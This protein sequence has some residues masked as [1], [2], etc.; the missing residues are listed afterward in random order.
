MFECKGKTEDIVPAEKGVK[1]RKKPKKELTTRGG[2][3]KISKRLSEGKP[4]GRRENR[5][6]GPASGA[7]KRSGD[8]KKFLTKAARC[9]NLI[10]SPDEGGGVRQEVRGE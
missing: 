3:A 5:I 7:E 2:S 8:Q 1:K 9:G 4:C 10:K 6:K